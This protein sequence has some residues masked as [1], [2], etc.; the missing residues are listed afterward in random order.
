MAATHEILSLKGY[1]L[2]IHYLPSVSVE[3]FYKL[4]TKAYCTLKNTTTLRDNLS[5]Q[6]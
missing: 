1:K 2:E 6:L 5:C 4:P 3:T